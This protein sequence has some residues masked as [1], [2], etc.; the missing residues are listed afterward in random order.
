[1]PDKFNRINS[2]YEQRAKRRKTNIILNT[3]ITIVLILI[4]IVGGSIFFTDSKTEKLKKEE[5]ARTEAQME[6]KSTTEKQKENKQSQEKQNE[7]DETEEQPDDNKRI[8]K[9]SDE[10]NVEKVIIDPSWKPIGTEQTGEHQSSWEMGSTDWNEK[11][12]AAAYAI[13]T[14]ADNITNWWTKRGA[15]PKNQ[16]VMTIS[17]KGSSDTYRVYLDW[18]DG[19][20][21]KPTEV[22]KLIE[23]DKGQE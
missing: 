21:W 16:A 3:L 4:L 12:K 7:P 9:E 18:I 10:P 14:S 17:E 11:E 23:N 5:A 1:M 15:D 8:E 13:G 2:R 6:N 19:E 22:K 20:G